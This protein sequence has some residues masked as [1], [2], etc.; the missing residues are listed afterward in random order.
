[1]MNDEHRVGQ[2]DPENDLNYSSGFA[3]KPNWTSAIAHKHVCH[4]QNRMIFFVFVYDVG[5]IL[6][7]SLILFCMLVA[8]YQA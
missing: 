2:G 4:G 1:M 8:I 5:C 6:N 3:H 7:V